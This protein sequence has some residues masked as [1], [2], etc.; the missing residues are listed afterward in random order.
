MK[1]LKGEERRGEEITLTKRGNTKCHKISAFSTSK[2]NSCFRMDR[3]QKEWE[4]KIKE[5][6]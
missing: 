4:R 3:S 2:E 6:A 5:K 1:K